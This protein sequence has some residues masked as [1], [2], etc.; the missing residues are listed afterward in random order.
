MFNHNSHKQQS[1]AVVLAFM[2]ILVTGTS[3]LLLNRLNNYSSNARDTETQIALLEAKKALLSYAMNYP[4]LRNNAEKGPGFLPCPAQNETGDP[5]SGCAV[6]TGTTLGRLP[7]KILGLSDFRE[8]GGELLWY[9]VSDNYKN[10]QSNDTVINSETPGLLSVDGG[11]DIVA[12]II[13]PGSPVVSQD[14]RPSINKSDYLE[15]VNANNDAATFATSGAGEFNDR[16][17]TITRQELMAVVEQRVINEIRAVLTNYFNDYVAY[18]WMATFADPKADSRRLMGTHSGNADSA[19][20][21][22]DSKEFVN[23]GIKEGDVV[24]NITDGSFGIVDTDPITPDTDTLTFTGLQFGSDNDFDTDDVY[25]VYKDITGMASGGST[26]LKLVDTTADFKELGIT[27]GDIVENTTDTGSSG[28]IYSVSTNE[29]VVT[30]LSG[31]A[32]NAFSSGDG[33]RIRSNVGRATGGST[34]SLIDTSKDFVQMGIQ[35]GDLV[36][37]LTDGSS[38][39]VSAVATN[40]LSLNSLNFGSDN[41]FATNDYYYLPRYN[42]DSN[43]REGLLSFHE[44]GKHFKTGFSVDWNITSANGAVVSTITN[45]GSPNATYVADLA[46]KVQ[47]SAGTLGTLTID[48]DNGWCIWS[49]VDIADC[50]GSYDDDNFPVLGIVT[51]GVNTST[52]TDANADFT[53]T[54][55]KRGDI[56]ENYDDEVAF[57]VSGTATAGSGGTTLED[58]SKNFN[59]LGIVPYYHLLHKTSSPAGR[60]L[61]TGIVDSDTLTITAFNGQPDV[62]FSSGDTYTIYTPQRVVVTGVNSSTQLTTSRLTA[63]APDFDYN[64]GGTAAIYPEFYQI[65]IGTGSLTGTADALSIGALLVDLTADF[66]EIEVNDIIE[67]TTDGSFGTVSAWTGTTITATLYD[68][69]GATTS[70]DPGDTY[71]I[72]F[73]HDVH[74]RRYEFQPQ[75]SGTVRTYGLSGE[76][77]RDVCLGYDSDCSVLGSPVTIPPHTTPIVTIRDYDVNNIEISNVSVAI[78]SSISGSIR[79]TDLDYYLHE[80]NDELPEWFVK[81][82]WH[83]LIYVAYSADYIPGGANDCVTNGNCVTLQVQRPSGNL[84]YNDREALVMVAGRQLSSQDRSDAILGILNYFENA[85]ADNDLVFDKSNITDNFNDQISVIAP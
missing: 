76:R 45:A 77:K 9:A 69:S 31:G 66:S 79:I 27:V 1:G 73:D 78:P 42:T 59:S 20:L 35:T 37:N 26:G 67:N 17:I 48:V 56:V 70:F 14:S 44:T 10:T 81:N 25:I 28:M 63:S 84:I 75:Y 7:Y 61:I 23:M 2:L 32:V 58:T 24:L 46:S 29:I 39:T 60:A 21:V 65:K 5:A 12:V 80:E 57:G 18:P 4:E 38:G 22:D 53:I 64:A 71:V 41:S 62:S 19:S 85:N 50:Q 16:V 8:S 49:G 6:S 33:Y 40:T 3:Y 54:A 51:S 47:T 34:T 11:N 74:T 52:L 68:S 43:T 55:V 30:A 82:K 36:V 13:S 15:D 83:Q 72:Y